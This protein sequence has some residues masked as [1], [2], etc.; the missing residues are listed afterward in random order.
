MPLQTIAMPTRASQ[1]G[2]STGIKMRASQKGN[3]ALAGLLDTL[4]TRM[5]MGR[6]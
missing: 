2:K 1:K 6:R 3:V 4:G 5:D